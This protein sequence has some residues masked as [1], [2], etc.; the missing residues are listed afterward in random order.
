VLHWCWKT[1]LAPANRSILALALALAPALDLH[2]QFLAV[3]P[4]DDA[5]K[6][7]LPALA[8][9]GNCDDDGEGIDDCKG[10]RGIHSHSHSQRTKAA[11]E[12]AHGRHAYNY[13]THRRLRTA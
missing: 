6:P 12:E 10:N 5:G 2:A 13:R 11:E 8:R 1:A 9:V 3:G 7:E 4:P